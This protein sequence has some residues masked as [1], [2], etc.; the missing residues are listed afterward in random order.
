[1]TVHRWVRRLAAHRGGAAAIE[2]AFV[3]P[4]MAIVVLGVMETG[5]A[6]WIQNTLQY[7]VDETARMVMRET[8]TYT[9]AEL[10]TAVR[11]A[12][13]GVGSA[14][15]TVTVATETLGGN[16]YRSITASIAHNWLIP[17]PI[18]DI[19]LSARGRVPQ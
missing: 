18:A 4:A 1:M 9:D 10:Q 8:T 19:T 5:R 2:A 14:A 12:A 11:N 7:A 16:D 6:M 15:I 3:L 13:A 17:L